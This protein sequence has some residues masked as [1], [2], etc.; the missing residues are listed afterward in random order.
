MGLRS[1]TQANQFANHWK[2][3]PPPAFSLCFLLPLLQVKRPDISERYAWFDPSAEA[4][5]FDD[6]SFGMV[7]NLSANVQV[8]IHAHRGYKVSSNMRRRFNRRH[9]S[10]ITAFTLVNPFQM[11]TSQG[12]QFNTHPQQLTLALRVYQDMCRLSL[13]C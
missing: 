11:M 3:H 1:G 9:S 13:H 8:E 12:G 4:G 10:L 6:F 7:P 5:L 2:P